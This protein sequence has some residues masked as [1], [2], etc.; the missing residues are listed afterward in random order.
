M[1]LIADCIELFFFQVPMED[2]NSFREM[3]EFMEA[4]HDDLLDQ[5]PGNGQVTLL[6]FRE[7]KRDVQLPCVTI[8][9]TELF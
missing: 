9:A 2:S 6:V 3:T 5:L 4:T 1:K 8:D 7:G